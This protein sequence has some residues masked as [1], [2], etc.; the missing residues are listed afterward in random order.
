VTLVSAAAPIVA[1]EA[2]SRAYCTGQGQLFVGTCYQP[3]DRSPEQKVVLD[4]D[5]S[6]APQ[7]LYQEYPGAPLVKEDGTMSYP[8][9]GDVATR[10]SRSW[11]RGKPC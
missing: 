3:V 1:Q 9:K 5:G 6:F 10:H 7:W 4:I 11:K 8:P 2:K